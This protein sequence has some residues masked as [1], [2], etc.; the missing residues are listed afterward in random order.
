MR[1]GS[2]NVQKNQAQ[3]RFRDGQGHAVRIQV[4]KIVSVQH[5]VVHSQV[6]DEKAVGPRIVIPAPLDA[7]NLGITGKTRRDRFDKLAIVVNL[8]LISL[9]RQSKVVP[10]I[11]RSSKQLG[12]VRNSDIP[13]VVNHPF[14]GGRHLHPDRRARYRHGKSILPVSTGR[15][16]IHVDA[17]AETGGKIQA[18]NAIGAGD[19]ERSTVGTV[20]ITAVRH[21][22]NTITPI[23]VPGRF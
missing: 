4:G 3:A 12:S 11:I 16:V 9:E 17:H 6:I 14:I 18:V 13:P 2:F 22:C 20:G 5:A 7:G 15:T 19:V 10:C 23:D 1:N 21:G 8:H